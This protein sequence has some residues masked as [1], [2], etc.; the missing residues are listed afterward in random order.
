[1]AETGGMLYAAFTTMF[2]PSENALP[3][4]GGDQLQNNTMPYLTIYFCITL[5]GVFPPRT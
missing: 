4:A 5:K 2:L 3:P 1:M